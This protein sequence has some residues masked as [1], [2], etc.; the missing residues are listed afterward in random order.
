MPSNVSTS[1]ALCAFVTMA[2]V[3]SV[4]ACKSKT[5]EEKVEPKA[6][7]PAAVEKLEVPPAPA[8]FPAL[9]IP[10]DNPQSPEKV[11]LGHQLFFDERLSV[12]GSRSCYSCHQNEH[13]NGGETS[14]AVGAG[15][16]QLTRHSP[17]IWNTA[18][19]EAFYWD[20][21]NKTRPRALRVG[22]SEGQAARAGPRSRRPA[23]A[24]SWSASGLF[25]LSL[26]L[27][28]T[29]LTSSSTPTMLRCSLAM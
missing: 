2:L 9:K 21:R 28:S 1:R 11:A 7:E 23:T 12:D 19:F 13:G 18:Y 3:A 27:A 22:A 5:A 4:A 14:L 24:P 25:W 10:T 16:K 17:V 29:R 6:V 20:G 8:E 26:R 15:E